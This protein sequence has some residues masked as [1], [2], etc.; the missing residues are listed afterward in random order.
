MTKVNYGSPVHWER[1]DW[2]EGGGG[3]WSAEH[4]G[5]EN[6]DQLRPGEQCECGCIGI[7][8]VREPELNELGM[9]RLGTSLAYNKLEVFFEEF[10]GLIGD[11]G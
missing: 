1:F 10:E 11:E 8:I 4:E 9:P 5:E 3:G 6:H 7:G 2:P